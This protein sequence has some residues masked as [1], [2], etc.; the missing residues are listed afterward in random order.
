MWE[1]T[2]VGS[3]FVPKKGVGVWYITDKRR[4]R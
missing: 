1:L 2:Y 4:R 3:F